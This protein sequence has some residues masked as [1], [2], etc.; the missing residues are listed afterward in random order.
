VNFQDY[1]RTR[2]VYGARLDGRMETLL[3]LVEERAPARVVDIGCGR[4][5]FP[6]EL[7]RRLGPGAQVF[8][9][10]VFDDVQ[11]D[12]WTYTAG[13]ITQGLPLPEGAFDCALLGEVIEHVPDPD[14][15]LAEVRRVLSPGGTFIVTTPNL[16]CWLNRLLVPLGVQPLFTETSSQ[17]TLGR[18]LPALGQG[19]P[20]IGHLKIFTHRS[21]AELLDR[22]GFDVLSRRGVPWEALPRPAFAADRVLSR[23]VPLASILLYVARRRA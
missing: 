5:L 1:Y 20:A 19:N 7:A 2:E 22:G 18:Y 12:G 10:D 4:G 11:P 9:I 13:D 15:L 21:L 16:V 6:A 17:V 23:L 3:R 8:G 14:A